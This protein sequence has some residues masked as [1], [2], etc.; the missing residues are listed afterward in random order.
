MTEDTTEKG[1]NIMAEEESMKDQTKFGAIIA[2]IGA[3]LGIVLVYYS[4]L[5]VY[6][7]IMLSELAEGRAGGEGIDD[8]ISVSKF[9][10]PVINDIILLGGALWAVG[11]YGFIRKE[12]WAWSMAVAANVLS[13]LSFF[14]LVPA[15]IRGIPPIYFLVFV[16]N[17][18]AFFLLLTV[19][20]KIDKK[21]IAISTV[22][23]MAYVMNFM[24]GVASTDMMLSSGN[25]IFIIG[26]RLSWVASLAWV[27]FVIALLNRKKF[28]IQ[29]GL[30]AA[31]V[32]LIAGLP[33][34]VVSAIEE[35]KFSMFFLAPILSI[36]LKITFLLPKGNKIISAWVNNS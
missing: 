9:V 8:G 26:Q 18:I 22:A 31:L 12:N 19:V 1:L 27:S 13:L 10:L 6:D 32:T 33:L 30:I 35:A 25:T 3:L 24:N 2:I 5:Q 20:R 21:I 34:G 28:V 7:P 14:M 4:F 29:L 11:A 36:I 23:G 15:I 17:I 16:P